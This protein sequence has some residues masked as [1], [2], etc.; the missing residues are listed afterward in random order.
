[1]ENERRTETERALVGYFEEL[2]N[3]FPVRILD[4]TLRD[5]TLPPPPMR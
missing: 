4:R 1:V 3:R 2:K 5:V